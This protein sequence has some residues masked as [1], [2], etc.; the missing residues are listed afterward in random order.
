MPRLSGSSKFDI[1]YKD[2][3]EYQD[4]ECGALEFFHLNI[5]FTNP[6]RLGREI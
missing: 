4:E 6:L 2:T 5:A 1:Q 3:N